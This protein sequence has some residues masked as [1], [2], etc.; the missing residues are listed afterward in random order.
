MTADDQSVA[1]DVSASERAW[2]RRRRVVDGDGV[3][4]AADD[5]RSDR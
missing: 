5:Q 2:R 1:C 4:S 3:W